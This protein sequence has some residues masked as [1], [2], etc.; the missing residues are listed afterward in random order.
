MVEESSPA[1]KYWK[2][3]VEYDGTAYVGWQRQDEG[4]SI[5]AAIE[6]AASQ[7]FS[8]PVVAVASGRTDAGVHAENQVVSIAV[9]TDRI[10]RSVW[11]GMNAH[12][13]PDIAVIQAEQM[14]SR[15][16]ARFDA[17]GKRYVYHFHDGASRSPL[18]RQRVWHQH[19]RLDCALMQAAANALVGQHDFSSFRAAGCGAT[20]TVRTVHRIEIV[21]DGDR[22]SM[23]VE[24]RGFLRH[25]VRTMAGTLV[26]VG[27][28]RMPVSAVATILAQK[29]R[30]CAGPTAPANGL[31]L[32]SVT[33]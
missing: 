24:G 23:E 25:M 6:Y 21:R 9:H 18:V 13:P 28:K 33:Y 2:L 31:T 16:H 3:T 14:P 12:L 11:K 26:Q 29:D 20:T 8:E 15:F 27:L 10:P 4:D 19:Q 30:S 32:V 22:V 5:Q 7:L 1:L 17:R